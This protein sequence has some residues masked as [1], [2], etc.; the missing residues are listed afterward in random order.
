MWQKF[1]NL[2]YS[3]I[4]CR[5]LK[6][7]L[8]LFFENYVFLSSGGGHIIMVTVQNTGLFPSLTVTLE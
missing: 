4:G 7:L 3:I 6:F 8:W 1:L 2:E 5:I